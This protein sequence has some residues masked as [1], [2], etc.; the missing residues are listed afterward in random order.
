[1]R[2]GFLQETKR[3]IY[4][5]QNGICA[6]EGCYTVI[7]SCHHMLHDTE[8]N[9]E[10]FPLFINSPMNGVGLCNHHHDQLQ[11]KY[12]ITE[13]QAEIYEEYLRKLNG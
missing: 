9:R 4:T 2:K 1:M 3:Q 7:Q 11:H 12:R 6:V 5:A 8:Y 10:R 13:K